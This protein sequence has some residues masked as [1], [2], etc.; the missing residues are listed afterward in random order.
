MPPFL[1]LHGHSDEIVRNDSLLSPARF[2][3]RFVTDIHTWRVNVCC[4]LCWTGLN[5]FIGHLGR[6]THSPCI[7]FLPRSAREDSNVPKLKSNWELTVLIS[8]QCALHNAMGSN[9]VFKVALQLQFQFLTRHFILSL[10]CNTSFCLFCLCFG[11]S[12]SCEK[13]GSHL[14]KI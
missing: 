2:L 4:L 9:N 14:K 7:W 13:I 11:V 5:W 12:N 6:A 10:H 8:I 3:L 1:I